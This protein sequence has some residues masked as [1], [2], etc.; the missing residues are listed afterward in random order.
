MTSTEIAILVW[1]AIGIGIAAGVFL[2]AR[3]AIQI[4]SVAYRVIE[5]QM[6]TRTAT[7]EAGLL[8]LALVAALVVTAFVAG[9]AVLVV[10]ASLLERS[11]VT[12]N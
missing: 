1:L 11:G 5:R 6:D 12:G 3:S 4:A 2:A 8:S 10:F 7:R 9:Y